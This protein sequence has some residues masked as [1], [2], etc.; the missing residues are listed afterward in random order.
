MSRDVSLF[1]EDI[2]IACERIQSYVR[3]MTFE[4][5]RADQKT[6]D[7]VTRNLEIIGEAA[8]QLPDDVTNVMPAVAWRDIRGLRIILAHK[9]F[10]V[11]DR[12]LWDAAATDIPL[13]ANTVRHYSTRQSGA[14]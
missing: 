4:Q 10:G 14:E 7:A 5:F 1:I 11:N 13:L 9:Y 3:G 8:S 2:L 6:K 12:V